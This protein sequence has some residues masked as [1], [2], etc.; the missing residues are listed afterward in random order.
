MRQTMKT[1][2]RRVLRVGVINT[3]ITGTV[4]LCFKGVRLRPPQYITGKLRRVGLV[5]AVLPNGQTLRLWTEDDDLIPNQLYWLGWEG[6]E[7]DT[8]PT[9]MKLAARAR[10]TLDIGS[11]VGLFSLVAALANPTGRVYAFEAMPPTWER[12]KQNIALNGLDNVECILGA[13]ANTE[14]SAD[15]Y[16]NTGI[17][18]AAESSLRRECTEAFLRAAGGEI[19]TTTVRVS[20]VDWFVR[21]KELT[22]VDLVKIDTEGV[23]PEVLEGMRETIE[24]YKPHLVCEVLKGFGTAERLESILKPH[25]YRYYLLTP[26]GPVLRGHVEPQP[27]QRWELRNYLFSTLPPDDVAGLC[28]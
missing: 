10:V 1:V 26:D 6:F 13:I 7:P 19:A 17:G 18:L 9:F 8:L 5:R 25:G 24:A 4:R 11:H 20:T 15:F 14:G 23:E 2:L 3:A 28:R 16:Y 22:C 27:D 12:L 21:E